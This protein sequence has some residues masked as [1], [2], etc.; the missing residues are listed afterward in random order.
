VRLESELFGKVRYVAEGEP[1][2]KAQCPC[3]D[4]QYIYWGAPNISWRCPPDGSNTP[5][6]RQAIF[7]HYLEKPLTNGKLRDAA[8]SGELAAARL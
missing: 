1:T 7:P 3:R 2:M 4:A 8:R 5:R 6:A